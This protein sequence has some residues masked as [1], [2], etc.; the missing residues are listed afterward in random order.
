M[1]GMIYSDIGSINLHRPKQIYDFINI[2]FW[3][4]LLSVTVG[5]FFIYISS[6]PI[7]IKTKV[8]DGR[9]RSHILKTIDILTYSVIPS[10]CKHR[11]FQTQTFLIIKNETGLT[12]SCDNVMYLF[13]VKYLY[14]EF[15]SSLWS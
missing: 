8:L 5:I 15:L 9:P 7:T 13:A 1:D 6:K 2:S 14:Y 10:V 4:H 3:Q 12:W 11:N